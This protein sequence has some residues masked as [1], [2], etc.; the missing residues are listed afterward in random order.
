MIKL[1]TPP[2][3]RVPIATAAAAPP[4]ATAA[5]A[6]GEADALAVLELLA[7]VQA[8]PASERAAAMSAPAALPRWPWPAF[9][10][11]AWAA[12]ALA[13]A[14]L[15]WRRSRRFRALLAGAS[16]APA[17]L[18]AEAAR[19]GRVMG[20]AASPELRLVDAP[21]APMLYGLRRPSLLLP[22]PLFQQLGPASRRTI[23]AHELA[24]ARRRDYLVRGLELVCTAAYWWLPT[25]PWLRRLLHRA[26]EQCCDA[27]V[28]WALP[29]QART[30]ADALLSTIDYLAD[31]PRL[32]PAIACGA[33]PF[34]D[35]KR[36]LTMIMT[37]STPRRLSAGGRLAVATA[38]AFFLPTL[39]TFAQGVERD[40]RAEGREQADARKEL[41]AL[42]RE[43]RDLRAQLEEARAA[44]EERAHERDAQA[45]EHA[46]REH[47]R[48]LERAAQ[49]E[50]SK[51]DVEKIVR[52][53]TE[54]AMK[55][56]HEHLREV[57]PEAAR[58]VEESVAHA[59]KEAAVRAREVHEALAR[60]HENDGAHHQALR[61]LL[62]AHVGG[63]LNGVSE[64]LK[65]AL[66]HAR[67]LTGDKD[68]LKKHLGALLQRSQNADADAQQRAEVAERRADE[69]KQ[70]LEDARAKLEAMRADMEAMRAEMQRLH[71]RGG[72]R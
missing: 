57:M 9:A 46:R 4:E 52:E 8:P 18:R 61:E 58:R 51:V 42:R 64:D 3:L 21:V 12:G 36:R 6:P 72:A 34:D 31:A 20:L 22:R 68:A 11:A 1:V 16:P 59:Q 14:L 24:H 60:L 67:E 47:V 53:A 33:G 71:G 30:Y 29:G 40:R 50:E 41:D 45:H 43:V 23:L 44:R 25:M 37:Q 27:W 38:A 5:R 69:L 65:K 49:R 66:A 26:E 28:T 7:L 54:H 55:H 62:H 70:A 15:A 17:D 35:V 2:I 63:N 10:A 32:A 19:L 56:V 48:A 13:V 39:P